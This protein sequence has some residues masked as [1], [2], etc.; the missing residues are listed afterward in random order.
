MFG[1]FAIRGLSLCISIFSMPLYLRYFGD[2]T[3]LGLWFTIL[4]V[5]N[6]ILA[7]DMGIGNG[8]RN[9]LTIAIAQ[10][11]KLDC[12]RLLSSAYFVLGAITLLL[13][14]C[15][16]LS[17]PLLDL[18]G[19]FNIDGESIPKDH[20]VTCVCITLAGI[21]ASFFFRLVNSIFY[22]LQLSAVNNL[23][24]FASSALLV[25]YLFVVPASENDIDNLRNIS[26]SYA[27]I[28]NLPLVLGSIYV[29]L[30]SALK[31]CRP[32][33]KSISKDAINRVLS[34][35]LVFLVLQ[36]LYMII[37]VTNE[38]FITR[39]YG[40]ACCVEYQVYYRIFS[41]ISSLMTLA[42]SPLWSAIT[43]AF[44]E[45]R[46]LWIKKLQKFLYL[47][48]IAVSV[49]QLVIL[50]LLQPLVNIWLGEKAIEINYATASAFVAYSIILVW[51]SIL[52]TLVSGL[53]N[54]KLQLF[55]YIFAVLF[56]ICSIALLH[57]LIPDWVMVVWLTIIGLLPYC[58]IQPIAI[59]RSINKLLNT[60]SC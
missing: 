48:A 44:A 51:I 24:H 52:S 33:I 17:I 42:L 14:F 12:K 10:D 58:F 38:F 40:A 26:I 56:K 57:D 60:K 7:F 3:V 18:N 22:A 36:V 16:Y 49:I 9:N 39:Y 6:W 8:L 46:Y 35:G 27:V 47:F 54:L 29:F 55:C 31:E 59:N 5:L 13:I 50:P 28:I 53:G 2:N 25:L 11:N 19:I 34:L 41:L 23:L 15:L 1:A 45:K 21:L 37:S 32:S 43:K 4:S 20:L 30:F